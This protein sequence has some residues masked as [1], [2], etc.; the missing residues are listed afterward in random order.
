MMRPN[1]R[2]AEAIVEPIFWRGRSKDASFDAARVWR[3]AFR[4]FEWAAAFDRL[5][6][7]LQTKLHICVE[8]VSECTRSNRV[9]ANLPSPGLAP[10]TNVLSL[11]PNPSCVSNGLLLGCRFVNCVKM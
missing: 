2:P 6:A 11:R 3:S 5:K 9:R 10:A 4:R 8:A 1:N 7:E